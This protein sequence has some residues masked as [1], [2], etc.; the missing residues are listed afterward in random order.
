MDSELSVCTDC[1]RGNRYE[2]EPQVMQTQAAPANEY[3]MAPSPASDP[4]ASCRPVGSVFGST[5]DPQTCG[6]T[7]FPHPA[8]SPLVSRHATLPPICRPFAA[9]RPFTPTVAAGSSFP[10]AS[11]LSSI[12][13]VL[14]QASGTLAPP[15]MLVTVTSTWSPVPATPLSTI[16]LLSVPLDPMVVTQKSTALPATSCILPLSTLLWA[17]GSSGTP[18]P[19]VT[20]PSHHPATIPSLQHLLGPSPKP[21]PS[22]PL[23][24][25]CYGMRPRLAGGG[26]D[27]M[28]SL[29]LAVGLWLR[30]DPNTV[31]LLGE[32]GPETFFIGVYILIAAGGLVMLVGFFGC[33]GAV[34]E[35]QCLLGLFFACLLVI[36]GAEVAAGVFGFLNKD[37]IIEEIKHFYDEAAGNNDNN[38]TVQ[39]YHIIVLA[40]K[41]SLPSA[42]RTRPIP[43][44]LRIW[45]PAKPPKDRMPEPTTD[46]EPEAAA[47]SV[48]EPTP[49]PIITPEPEPDGK[50]DQVCEPATSSI[51]VGVLVEY[52]GMDWSLTHTPAAENELCLASVLC[53]EVEDV[54][55]KSL[56][57]GTETC[58]V[59][60]EE[61]FNSKLFIV[62]YVG[63]GI[64]G[65]MVNSHMSINVVNLVNFY[66][67]LCLQPVYMYSI[68]IR[69][70]KFNVFI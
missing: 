3:S 51:S 21:P 24:I 42:S 1:L 12:T 30:L 29:V 7:R 27:L 9:L 45:S 69:G 52:E 68:Y 13:S 32:D 57:P 31:S 47:M 60:I 46:K 2:I 67:H 33:C 40:N 36:F 19:R 16:S 56:Q 41:G 28:G 53:K 11:P 54:I 26:R 15:P 58:H 62:G 59:A 66:F 48:P 10:S 6:S 4:F 50:S 23:F 49:E 14:P 34:R 64:A 43:A 35:S 8:G 70:V 63:I 44:P 20:I 65:V 55:P 38:T 25:F 39:S 37:K 18:A 17:P 22:L 61:F 5:R